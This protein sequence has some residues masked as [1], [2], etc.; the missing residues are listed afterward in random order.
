MADREKLARDWIEVGEEGDGTRIVLRPPDYPVPRSR[1][2]RRRLALAGSGKVRALAPG[3]A[4]A[5]ESAGQGGW[6]LRGDILVLE[7]PGWQGEYQVERLAEDIL[8]LRRR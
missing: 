8:V 4:D 7:L 6:S 2:G 1:G 5:L 3:P